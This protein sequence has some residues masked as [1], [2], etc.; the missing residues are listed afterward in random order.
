MCIHKRWRN[1]VL[2]SVKAAQEKRKIATLPATCHKTLPEMNEA[3]QPKLE[4]T[5]QKS[6]YYSEKTCDICARK[7]ANT[8]TLSKHVKSVH[9][10]IKPFICNICG[11]KLARKITLMVK[12]K[13][14]KCIVFCVSN[15][16][17]LLGSY[18]SAYWRKT[19]SVQCM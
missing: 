7:F 4:N 6:K 16:I 18:A 14:V 10:K 13:I 15:T 8:K 12:Q 9:N 17:L 3:L 1:K 11:K 5:P 2:K 19:P